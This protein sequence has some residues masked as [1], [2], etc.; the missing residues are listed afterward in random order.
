MVIRFRPKR[1]TPVRRRA[2]IKFAHYDQLN[3]VRKREEKKP[4]SSS[5]KNV[6]GGVA[7]SWRRVPSGQWGCSD[8]W[9][10]NAMKKCILS[11]YPPKECRRS[12]MASKSNRMHQNKSKV[13]VKI[14]FYSSIKTRYI[15]WTYKDWDKCC[16]S[17][18][19]HCMAKQ[20]L[21][22]II[23]EVRADCTSINQEQ[24]WR[25]VINLS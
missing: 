9:A 13:S 22:D 8:E 11:R 7:G 20:L 4:E 3:A 25:D 14:R 10:P 2:C 23:C 5:R 6:K 21:I 18:R 15:G 17:S 1:I 19:K 16:G 12:G 24:I